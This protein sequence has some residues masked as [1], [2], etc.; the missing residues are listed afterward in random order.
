MFR[1]FVC[2]IVL[3]FLV[4]SANAQEPL[5]FCLTLTGQKSTTAGGDITCMTGVNL[6]FR[7]DEINALLASQTVL[8]LRKLVQEIQGLRLEMKTYN[9]NL[10]DARSNFDKT[11]KEAV[12]A[13]ERWRKDSLQATLDSVA[14]VPSKLASNDALRAP[15]LL[16]LKDELPKDQAFVDAVQAALKK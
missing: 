4:H 2:G 9:Q 1:R 8:E 12:A 16:W 6:N 5:D 13:Q 7:R 15:L 3:T 14:G 11:S 10:A